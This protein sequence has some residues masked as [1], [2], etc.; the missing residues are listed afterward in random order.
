MGRHPVPD[1]WLLNTRRVHVSPV[2]RK[3]REATRSCALNSLMWDMLGHL[4][5]DLMLHDRFLDDDVFDYDEASAMKVDEE[6]LS[7]EGS[8]FR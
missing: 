8:F 3:G 7:I 2:Q 4:V 5:R 6:E 1:D